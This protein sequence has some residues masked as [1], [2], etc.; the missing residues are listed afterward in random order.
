MCTC[1]PEGGGGGTSTPKHPSRTIDKSR[2]Q[3]M[4]KIK[5][6]T[7]HASHLKNDYSL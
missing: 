5:H 1:W 3:E 6:D 7:Y 2:S 4:R